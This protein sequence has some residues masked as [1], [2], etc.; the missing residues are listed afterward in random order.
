MSDGPVMVQCLACDKTFQA[1]GT[2]GHSRS[3]EHLANGGTDD[4][5]VP[6]DVDDSLVAGIARLAPDLSD[7]ELRELLEENTA[8]RE[9]IV[10]LEKEKARLDPMAQ[11]PAW[12]NVAQVREWLGDAHVRMIGE[13]ELAA[14]NKRRMKDGLPPMYSSEP[15]EYERQ[16]TAAS[17]K[18]VARMVD[19]QTRW[20]EGVAEGKHKK[21]RTFKMIAPTRRCDRHDE[22]T[23]ALCY[24]HGTMRQ[25]PVELQINNGAASLN[26][27]IERYKRKGFKPAAPIRC[28][29]VD[30][31]RPAAITVNGEWAHGMYCSLEH[32]NYMEGS[33]TTA[34]S[35]NE[36]TVYE[37]TL[38]G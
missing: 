1:I 7:A 11:W 15:G 30:C 21:M 37:P 17:E 31:Y 33:K 19:E 22:G 24:R 4:M 25:I 9:Q 23:V 8:L 6:V 2:F 13:V 12:E 35:G 27:P 32:R 28:K 5:I 20:T 14:E 3:K 10:R 34:S 29:L 16:V 36:M 38:V 26:D 18:S